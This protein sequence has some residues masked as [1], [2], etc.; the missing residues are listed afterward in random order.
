MGNET[1]GKKD[2]EKKKQ[3]K[4]EDKEEKKL[5]RKSNNDKGKSLDEMMMYL[6]EDGNLTS[7]PPDP[8]KK[9]REISIESIQIGVP[10]Q[11]DIEP[12]DTT[13][14]GIVKFFD[15]SKGYGFIND[16]MTHE[17]IFVHINKL[18]EPIKEG[19]KVTFETEKGPRG[20]SAVNV[21]KVG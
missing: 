6:D 7:T 14:N 5:N 8:R 9:K 12:V 4:R 15:L 10:K 1:M 2:R 19:D 17:S 16:I 18:S 3:K 20:L 21:K 11:E 13:R